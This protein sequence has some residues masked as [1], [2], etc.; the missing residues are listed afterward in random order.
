MKKILLFASA[1]LLLAVSCTPEDK[2]D[3]KDTLGLSPVLCNVEATGGEVE[4]SITGN[5]AWT[6]ELTEWSTEDTEWCVP[7]VTE[8]EGA[9]TL[10]LTVSQNTSI[11]DERSVVIEVASETK[12]LQARLTQGTLELGE[13]EVLITGLDGKGRVWSAY[14]LKDKGVFETDVQA[15]TAAFQFN[16]SKAWP[17]DPSKNNGVFNGGAPASEGMVPVEGFVD[18]C[19]SYSEPHRKYSEDDPTT[20]VDDDDAWDD[21]NDPCP[22]GWRVPTSWE[23][24]QT[25]GYTDAPAGFTEEQKHFNGVRV[26]AGQFGFTVSGFVIGL[27]KVL[28]SDLTPQNITEKGGLF[29]PSTGWINSTGYT[30]RTWLVCLWGATSHN[31]G[32]A[33]LYLSNWTDYCDHWGWGDGHKEFATIVRCIKK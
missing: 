32:I 18:A 10:K 1:A 27:G 13:G 3:V 19:K 8:G 20:P 4:L 25:L 14:N 31:D 9:F 7:N 24:I 29:F 12:T 2:P 33:G 6:V 21:A 5:S 30:D 11:T 23:V 16:R 22:E 28:P 15:A 17:F 26:E